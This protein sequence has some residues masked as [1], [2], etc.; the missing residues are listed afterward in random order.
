MSNSHSP[1]GSSNKYGGF[2]KKLS[3]QLIKNDDDSDQ[4]SAGA[5]Q[6]LEACSQIVDCLVDRLL[7]IEEKVVG[8]YYCRI[9]SLEDVVFWSM[10]ILISHLC[11]HAH[12][13]LRVPKLISTILEQSG[14][15]ASNSHRLIGCLTTLYL[16]SKFQPSML[17]RHAATLQP[18]L[19]TKCNV[20]IWCVLS[21]YYD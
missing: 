10:F 3:F 18:Y 15:K 1:H 2:Y 21:C 8:E 6:V 14:G 5:K 20:S 11:L 19:S 13:R 17:V 4:L 7:T 9:L 16:M 12:I